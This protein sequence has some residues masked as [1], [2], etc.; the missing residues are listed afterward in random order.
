MAI[1]VITHNNGRKLV[2]PYDFGESDNTMVA[3]QYIYLN[4][5][6]IKDTVITTGSV[7][8]SSHTLRG[9]SWK[10]AYPKAFLFERLNYY[11]FN[12]TEVARELKISRRMLSYYLKEYGL[13]DYCKQI[14]N[15]MQEVCNEAIELS[16][17][18]T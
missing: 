1:I 15:G 5:E 17:V 13:L 7:I 9:H 11:N 4:F 10:V 8:P 3:Q 2:L 16:R 14:R 18:G 12:K 6:D